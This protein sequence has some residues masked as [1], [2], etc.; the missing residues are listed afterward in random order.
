MMSDEQQPCDDPIAS[1]LAGLQSE[2]PCRRA[3]AAG[4][5]A[6]GG[7][8]IRQANP[9]DPPPPEAQPAASRPATFRRRA[10]VVRFVL[11]LALLALATAALAA[12][13]DLPVLNSIAQ[14]AIEV[15]L[16]SS[17]PIRRM[18]RVLRRP[19]FRRLRK[20]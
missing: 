4:G 10:G 19:L 6:A 5:R 11:L 14:H 17:R 7:S 12:L 13:W 3:Q 1:V 20:V 15:L 2:D 18:L 16:A 9:S 8:A